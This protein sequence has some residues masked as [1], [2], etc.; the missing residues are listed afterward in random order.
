MIA[1]PGDVPAEREII[2]KVIHRWNAIHSYARKIVLLPIGWETHAFPQMGSAPQAIINKQV[3]EKADLVVGVFWTKIGTKTEEYE[4]GSVEE[5]ELHIEAKKPAM[6]Y[7]SES[8]VKLGSVDDK[9]YRR[10]RAF[11]NS[12]RKRSLYEPYESIDDFERKFSHQLQLTLN[13]APFFTEQAELDGSLAKAFPSRAPILSQESTIL[14]KEAS[15]DFK[16]VVIYMQTISGTVLHTNGRNLISSEESRVVASWNAA[17]KQL[18]EAK[19]IEPQGDMDGRYHLTG[20]GYRVAD[21][22]EIAN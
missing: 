9:Q 16:G 10:L 2:R 7:F 8:P 11:R 20:E 17:V 12:C 22:I 4:S 3:L 21:A 15:Q 5:I 19:Y 6:L 14:L 1:S 13:G 18:I